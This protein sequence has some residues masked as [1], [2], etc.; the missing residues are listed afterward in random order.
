MATSQAKSV[1]LVYEQDSVEARVG[2]LKN[3]MG[4]L[5]EGQQVHIVTTPSYEHEI[6]QRLHWESNT[7]YHHIFPI[8]LPRHEDVWRV[9]NKVFFVFLGENNKSSVCQFSD[10]H[11]G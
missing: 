3:A 5:H 4:L 7:R 6:K 2:R 10:V 9:T 11:Q 1:K 8:K